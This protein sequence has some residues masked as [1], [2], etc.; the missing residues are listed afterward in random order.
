MQFEHDGETVCVSAAST[1]Q[2]GKRAAFRLL[3]AT[4]MSDVLRSG[5]KVRTWEVSLS[6]IGAMCG[7]DGEVTPLH[8]GDA[9]AGVGEHGTGCGTSMPSDPHAGKR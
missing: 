5:A 4:Q 7:A 3:T 2:H 8:S 9:Q 6:A 1:S